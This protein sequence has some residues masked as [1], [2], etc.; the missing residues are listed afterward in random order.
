MWV[1]AALHYLCLVSD[2][3]LI[4]A[5]IFKLFPNI[6]SLVFK[7]QDDDSQYQCKIVAVCSS[8]DCIDLVKVNIISNKFK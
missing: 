4:N 7:D 1:V 8:T 3:M 2:P 6:R 5:H